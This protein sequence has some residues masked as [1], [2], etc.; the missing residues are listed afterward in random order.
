M[1]EI[2]YSKIEEVFLARSNLPLP[3]EGNLRENWQPNSNIQTDQI[4]RFPLALSISDGQLLRASP[5][6]RIDIFLMWM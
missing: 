2:S 3:L 5:T 1:L 6:V 4:C